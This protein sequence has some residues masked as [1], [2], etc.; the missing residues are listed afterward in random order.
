MSRTSRLLLLCPL[1]AALL[2]QTS[3]QETASSSPLVSTKLIRPGVNG[4]AG[5]P[6]PGA[7]LVSEG[8]SGERADG[9]TFN[10]GLTGFFECAVSTHFA[11][12]VVPVQWMGNGSASGHGD[13]SVGGKWLFNRER[14]RRPAF[15]LGYLSKLPSA[16]RHFGTG[17]ADYKWTAYMEKTALATRWTANYV[18]KLEG[19]SLGYRTQQMLSIGALRHIHG[20]WGIA[21][22]SYWLRS[23]CVGSGGVLGAATYHL[24]PAFSVHLGLERGLGQGTSPVGTVWGF[25]TLIKMK[26][27]R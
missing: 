17:Y 23:G 4:V 25:T 7:C 5:I 1:A 16:A 26:D 10:F 2:A 24:R 6:T 9:G 12:A 8:A 22:Q 27:V 21:A 14:A 20:R 3:E 15:A 13:V 11:L 18:V 19:L